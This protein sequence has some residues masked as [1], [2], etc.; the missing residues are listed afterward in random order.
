MLVGSQ[1]IKNSL[2]DVLENKFDYAVKL[3][4]TSLLLEIWTLF[5]SVISQ[6]EAHGFLGDN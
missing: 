1:L 4:C 6:A 2:K 5:P 3:K